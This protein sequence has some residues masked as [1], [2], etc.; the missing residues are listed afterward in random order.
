[1][2]KL[3]AVLG[4]VLLAAWGSPALGQDDLCQVQLPSDHGWSTGWVNLLVDLANNPT[5]SDVMLRNN[6]FEATWTLDLKGVTTAGLAAPGAM[7]AFEYAAPVRAG[8]KFPV[9]ADFIAD[10]RKV[11]TAAFQTSV[12]KVVIEN[13]K[14]AGQI[15]TVPV[16]QAHVPNLFGVRKLTVRMT[17]ADGDSAGEAVLTLPDWKRFERQVRAASRKAERHRRAKRCGPSIFI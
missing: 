3:G 1:M 14:Y 8:V 12:G 13:D 16:T 5:E 10:D 17:D 2:S 7:T 15:Q 4:L 11:A 6:R 9:T